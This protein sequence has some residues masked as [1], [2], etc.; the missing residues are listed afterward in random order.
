MSLPK[1]LRVLAMNHS[2]TVGGAARAA[3]RVHK[4]VR[5]LGVDSTLRVNQ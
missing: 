3:Y 2:D 1:N 4:A 5:H